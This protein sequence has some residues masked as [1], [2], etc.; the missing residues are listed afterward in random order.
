MQKRLCSQRNIQRLRHGVSLEFCLGALQRPRGMMNL[1]ANEPAAA[2]E[3]VEAIAFRQKMF[4]GVRLRKKDWA[5]RTVVP[6]QSRRSGSGVVPMAGVR[7][8][9]ILF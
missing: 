8:R 6:S 1:A 2:V 3:G 5:N 4:E 7:D 9:A